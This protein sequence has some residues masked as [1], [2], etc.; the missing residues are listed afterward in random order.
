MLEFIK[1][2]I[3]GFESIANELSVDLNN[4]EITMIQGR[5]GSGKTTIFAAL[6]WGLYGKDLRGSSSVVGT[7]V[8][9]QPP[10]YKGTKV[11]IFF[12][13]G[14]DYCQI[15]RCDSYQ[16]EVMG[17]KGGNRLIYL[18]NS[19]QVDT[20]FKS[21]I[22]ALI[23]HDLGMSHKTFLHSVMFGQGMTR[24]IQETGPD[25]KDLFTEI[26]QLEY[27]NKARE[28][29]NSE[30][31]LARTELTSC[32]NRVEK[33]L[34]QI[35]DIKEKISELKQEKSRHTDS[36]KSEIKSL[37]EYNKA[38]KEEIDSLSKSTLSKS[39]DKLTKELEDID[40]RH[41]ELSGELDRCNKMLKIPILDLVDK[42]L[43]FLE[44]K[45]YD[46][47]RETLISMKEAGYSKIPK[48]HED[49][50]KCSSDYVAKQKEIS[51][52]KLNLE[53][54]DHLNSL[55]EQRNKTISRIKANN[56]DFDNMIQSCNGK[57]I[58][59]NKKLEVD[60]SEYESIQ[61]KVKTLQWVN[62]I[63]LGNKGLKTYLFQSSMGKINENLKIYSKVI[64]FNVQ[65]IVDSGS[66]KRDFEVVISMDGMDVS[67]KELSG[68]QKQLV[69][70]VMAFAMNNA[71]SQSNGLNI[72]FLDEVFESL[73]S[74]NIDIVSSLIKKIYKN[75]TLFLITHQ[76]TLPIANAHIL[77][78]TKENGVSKYTQE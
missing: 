10:G 1:I 64:G 46:K 15:I 54:I 48:L 75:K 74:D 22:Q 7:W 3:Q 62:D 59:L 9:Y 44:S 37:K 41:S 56:K 51:N 53:K 45:D 61:S 57:L 71:I 31:E 47:L 12:K 68:G 36:Q 11:E 63:A 42:M 23:N 32:K 28:I 16:G 6:F 43:G 55:I 76:G 77:R 33:D 19:E 8:K 66:T 21:D 38:N 4:N 24:L 49:L 29:S 72:A 50:K 69:N 40:S 52:F 26:F 35:Q 25:K 17:S 13:S 58:D 34:D 78:V 73:S 20:R 2:N 67:Y 18:K 65:F 70:L 27:I 14:H 30:L 60:K 5:N 39:L